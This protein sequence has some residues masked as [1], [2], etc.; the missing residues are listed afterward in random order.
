MLNENRK[1]RVAITG[2]SGYVGS[3]LVY[4]LERSGLDVFGVYRK[5][6]S[7]TKH[8][9][10]I[11]PDFLKIDDL[12]DE[13]HNIDFV[14]YLAGR[15]HKQNETSS[16]YLELQRLNNTY[17]AIKF[18]TAA[19]KSNVQKFIYI[20]SVA[21][22]GEK[23]N[24]M[25][26]DELSTVYPITAYAK[27][28]LDAEIKLKKVFLGSKTELIIIRPPMVYGIGA[29][30]NFNSLTKIFNFKIP[31]PLGGIQNSRSFLNIENFNHIIEKI[32]RCEGDLT[33]TY[34]ISDNYD[35]STTDFLQLVGQITNQK[36][37]LF[38]LFPNFQKKILQ[39]SGK[40]VLSYSLYGDFKIDPSLLIS[41]LNLELPFS[42]YEVLKIQN[43]DTV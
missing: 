27:S 38:K 2:A 23:N 14:V 40:R 35:L 29:P 21:V 18:A 16:Q 8:K 42:P 20:S 12:K 6:K 17:P 25:V 4:H 19:L 11:L 1:Y 3:A 31:L 15:A 33:G 22:Y 32:I 43:K 28:K 9:K 30:G 5:N 37:R 34:L 10:I 36:V 13:L 24:G 26:F 7:Y 41:K 39:K